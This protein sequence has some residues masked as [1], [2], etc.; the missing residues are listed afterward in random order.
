MAGSEM[1]IEFDMQSL[2]IEFSGQ[3]REYLVILGCGALVWSLWSLRNG[4]CF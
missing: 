3:H 2:A 4:A 1:C